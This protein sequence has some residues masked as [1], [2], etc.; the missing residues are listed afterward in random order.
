MQTI[1]DFILNGNVEFTP[2]SVVAI[3]V[4]VIVLE[5][6]SSMVYSIMGVG[7]K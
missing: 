4:F 7:R 1:I 3:I 6:I 2:Y 5:T